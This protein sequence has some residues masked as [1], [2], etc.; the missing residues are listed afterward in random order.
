MN[1]YQQ[2]KTWKY[3]LIS[4]AVIIA[5]GSLLYTNYLVKNIAKSERTR[6]QVWALSMKQMTTSDD[7]DFLQY[8]F[9]VR[10]SSLVPA[11]VVNEKDAILYYR[12]LDSTKTNIKIPGNEK[13][14]GAQKYDPAYY[15]SELAYMKKQHPPIT[16]D[17]PM[18][19][20]R[21]L[22]YYKDSALLSELRI[23]PYIQLSVI[24]IFLLVAYTAFNTSRKSEQNQVWVG[25]AK[26]TAHQLGTPISS[27]MAWIELIKDKF[28]AEKEPLMA[29]MEN[30]VKRLEIIADRFSK[31][32][33]KPQL[34]GHSVYYVIKDFV[35]YFSVRVSSNINFEITGNPYLRADLNVPLFDWVLENLLKNAVNAIEN[36]GKVKVE[37]SQS[38]PKAGQLLKHKNQ[39][40]IDVTDTGKGIPRSKFETVFQPG[41]TTRKRGWGLGLSL[42]RRIIKNYHNGLIFVRESEIGK[43]TTFRIVLKKSQNDK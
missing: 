20:T 40:Y 35:D 7:N 3:I 18:L 14:K 13:V 24:A 41:Y 25:L 15:Q 28:H 31:I 34:E 16:L 4:F 11:I 37:I 8:V 26:E 22:V 43:G 39:I 2:K 32:G 19:S 33:S 5:S 42:T 1:P 23:F 30:D 6:A 29:E 9:A 36:K 12:G 38:K 27:L 17:M 21:W 10:D